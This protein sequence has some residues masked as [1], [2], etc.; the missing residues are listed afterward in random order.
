MAG[1]LAVEQS[2]KEVIFRHKPHR[3]SWFDNKS[4]MWSD[5]KT[6]WIDDHNYHGTGHL[7]YSQHET[8]IILPKGS[9]EKLI[10]RK[11]TWK[12]EPIKIR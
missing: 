5:E 4:G 11:M 7:G 10:G 9:I 6:Y 12:N 8:R 2:G 3:V 1:W